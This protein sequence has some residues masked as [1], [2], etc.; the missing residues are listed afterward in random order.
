MQKGR[1]CGAKTS[2]YCDFHFI[3]RK[4]YIRVWQMGCVCIILWS[5][6]CCS[7]HA[8]SSQETDSVTLHSCNSPVLYLKSRVG[9]YLPLLGRRKLW[10]IKSQV[11]LGLTDNY[12]CR[13]SFRGCTPFKCFLKKMRNHFFYLLRSLKYQ[14][15]LDKSQDVISGCLQV[16]RVW[17]P[18]CASKITS[19]PC[20]SSHLTRW[21]WDMPAA[22]TGTLSSSSSGMTAIMYSKTKKWS[23]SSIHC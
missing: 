2:K 11:P 12:T 18:P 4:L 1:R 20:D 8:Y 13:C 9:I 5:D 6:V 10:F 23:S 19:L 22:E 3:T 21:I 7:A 17:T 15:C 16:L 14:T